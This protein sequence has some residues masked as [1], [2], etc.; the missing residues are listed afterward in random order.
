MNDSLSELARKIR[1]KK[2][3]K[4]E[5]E[6]LK[7]E[8]IESKIERNRRIKKA[9]EIQRMVR[10]FLSRKKFQIYEDKININTIIEYL[11]EKKVKRIR[12]HSSQIISYFF[13]K[14]IDKQRKIKFKLVQEFKIHCSDLIKSFIKG[15]IIRKKISAQ[16]API[17]KSKSKLEPY[18]LSY[19][20]RLMLK[21][22]TIQNILS[23][24][25]NIKFF[26]KDAQEPEEQ[27]EL[28]SK[29]RKKYNE[30]Y[31]IYYQN[32]LTKEWVDE[33]RTP[34][35]WLKNYHKLLKG[36]EMPKK[37]ENK[38]LKNI[39]NNNSSEFKNIHE[40]KKNINYDDENNYIDEKNIDNNIYMNNNQ[41]MNKIY[42][43]DDRPIKPMKNNNFMET[44]NPFGI[45]EEMKKNEKIPKKKSSKKKKIIQKKENDEQAKKEEEDNQDMNINNNLSN[46]NTYDERPIGV[47]KI[48]YNE[49]FGDG[50][51][52]DENMYGGA[53]NSNKKKNVKRQ[54]SSRKKPVY[55]ARKAIEEAKL[56]EKKEGKK[57]KP[58]AFRE[59]VKEMKKLSAE[60]KGGITSNTETSQKIEKNT[61][62]KNHD[63]I[64][65]KQRKIEFE[66]NEIN[67]E[68]NSP[69]EDKKIKRIP[70]KSRRIETKDMAMRRKLHELERSPPPMLNIK[71]VKSK[72]ECWGPSNESKQTRNIQKMEINNIKNIKRSKNQTNYNTKNNSNE[73]KIL[74]IIEYDQNEDDMKQK[75]EIK[76]VDPK[77]VEEKAIKIVNK[78]I[79]RIENQIRNY[80]TEFNLDNYFK[81]KERKMM[82]Y[83]DIPYIKKD[84]NYVK[85]YSNEIYK[86]L[87]IHLMEQYQDLK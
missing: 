6:N 37:N 63:E 44:D 79:K 8:A 46:Y 42:K 77:K 76:V 40:I 55:D 24:I 16:L 34:D 35:P 70:M 19:K 65:I 45:S 23:D 20:T 5:I 39:D 27:K 73:G 4:E 12:K 49:M 72:I 68:E 15:I 21:C 18:F 3:N 66:D 22:K 43:E 69:F 17:R 87:V 38:K 83:G 53:L 57:E 82:E 67:N 32:K 80:G 2:L 30:F 85:K 60:E 31:L 14:Y 61:K 7:K 86:N 29:L 54:T 81:E 51:E 58:S 84:Y 74:N 48:D 64:P 52:F 28:N 47:K 75:N 71:G 33:E 50:Q 26:L 9:I 11:Y 62:Y 41:M 1:S 59:F 36:E 78:K 25:A 10:G 13:F 56:R